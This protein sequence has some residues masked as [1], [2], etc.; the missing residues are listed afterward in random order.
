VRAEQIAM[1]EFRGAQRVLISAV[2]KIN[3]RL[4][5][6]EV[7]EQRSSG[8]SRASMPG[9]WISRKELRFGGTAE[10]G[11]AAVGAFPTDIDF[12]LVEE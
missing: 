10:R 1:R 12:R 7:M 11:L 6:R 2:V 9:I 8:R 5:V 3:V 4:G